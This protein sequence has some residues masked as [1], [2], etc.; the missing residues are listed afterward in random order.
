MAESVPVNLLEKWI[1]DLTSVLKA[2]AKPSKDLSFNQGILHGP[3][4]IQG[5]ITT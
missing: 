3:E 2:D 5:R 4:Q 1:H